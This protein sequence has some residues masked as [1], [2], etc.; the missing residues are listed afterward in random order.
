MVESCCANNCTKRFVKAQLPHFHSF[1]K[2]KELHEKWIIAIKESEVY[3]KQT[4]QNMRKSFPSGGHLQKV[5]NE[6]KPPKRLFANIAK[7]KPSQNEPTKK[8]VE[9]KLSKQGR[10]ERKACMEKPKKNFESNHL[11]KKKRKRV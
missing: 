6:R 4:H 1:P 9:N 11:S 10:I 3:A 8:N 2:D 5:K 7:A